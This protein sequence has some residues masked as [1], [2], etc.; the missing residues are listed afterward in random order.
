MLLNFDQFQA[1]NK[2]FKPNPLRIHHVV[3][4]S[5]IRR[6]KFKLEPLKIR[7]GSLK[8]AQKI[9]FFGCGF[10]EFCLKFSNELIISRVTIDS[11]E[12]SS[13]QFNSTL[14]GQCQ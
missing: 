11:S 5:I 14:E 10:D 9:R 3:S 4:R 7:F 8:L 2:Q 12:M 13:K 6:Q 1:Q